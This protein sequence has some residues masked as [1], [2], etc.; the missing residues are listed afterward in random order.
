MDMRRV[1]VGIA[2]GM[3]VLTLLAGLSAPRE[4]DRNASQTAPAAAP[5]EPPLTVVMRHP[6]GA[7]P[8]LRRVRSGVR[9]LLRV[10]S[11]AAGQVEVEGLG[12]VQPVDP[13]TPATFDVLASRAG[14]Y[15]VVF[16]PAR[17]DRFA[18]GTLV[19]G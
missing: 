7:R 8:P 3:L 11:E 4:Q 14:R 17:G 6:A 19:V 9:V 5:V 2:V 10:S 18:V 16:L 15:R 1:L 13:A 12:L